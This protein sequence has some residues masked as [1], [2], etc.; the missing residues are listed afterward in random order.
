[1]EE[2]NLLAQVLNDKFDLKVGIYKNGSGSSIRVS[3]KSMPVLQEL[4]K[5][6]MPSMMRHKISL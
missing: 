2:V 4:L 3:T 1:L 5:D 6:K